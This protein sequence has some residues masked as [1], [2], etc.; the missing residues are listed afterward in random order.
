MSKERLGSN[1]L[2]WIIQGKKSRPSNISTPDNMDKP[3]WVKKTYGFRPEIIELIKAE[4]Y[5][6]REEIQ[7]VLDRILTSYYVDKQIAPLPEEK[8]LPNL[9]KSLQK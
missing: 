9:H 3:V 4:A 8:P 5:W 6:E 7:V 2:D 1:P